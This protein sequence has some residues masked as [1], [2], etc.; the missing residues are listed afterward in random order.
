MARGSDPRSSIDHLHMSAAPTPSMID[1]RYDQMFPTL[2]AWEGE[3]VRRLG[4]TPGFAPGE[5]LAKIGDVGGRLSVILSGEV[6]VTRSDSSGQRAPIVTHGPGAFLGELAQLA[7]RPALVDA[8]ARGPVEA[9]IIPPDRL[10]ALLIAEAE[11]GERIMRAL[12]LRGVGLIETGAGGAVIVGR[13][14]GR[15]WRIS[16]RSKARACIIG[17]R[18]LRRSCAPVRRSRSSAPAIRRARRRSISPVR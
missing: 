13:A 15:P 9:L 11:L 6:D 5:P 3:R 17:L 7:G 1:T 16:G 18:R 14:G 2:D 4:R 10:R 12:I 8:I